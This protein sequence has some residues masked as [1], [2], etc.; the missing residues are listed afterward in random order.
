MSLGA[1]RAVAQHKSSGKDAS[2][3]P[4]RSSLSHSHVPFRALFGTSESNPIQSGIVWTNSAGAS[5][6]VGA[7]R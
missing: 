7:R 6:V 2:L 5:A 4:T 3:R 1:V